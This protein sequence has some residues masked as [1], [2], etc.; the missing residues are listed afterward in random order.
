MDLT[1]LANYNICAILKTHQ[2]LTVG[3]EWAESVLTNVLKCG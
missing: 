2:V 1:E 3:K